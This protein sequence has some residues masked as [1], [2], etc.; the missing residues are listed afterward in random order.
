MVMNIMDAHKTAD[1]YVFVI[2]VL[3]VSPNTDGSEACQMVTRVGAA[4]KLIKKYPNS[5]YIVTGGGH[6]EN[7]DSGAKVMENF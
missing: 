1:K 6:Y 2:V 7:Q 4:I 3:G 5:S